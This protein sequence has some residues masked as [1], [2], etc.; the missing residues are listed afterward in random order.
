LEILF[1][2]SSP[3]QHHERFSKLFSSLGRV[4]SVFLNLNQ[5]APGVDFGLVVFAD[6]DITVE[7]AL[8]FSAPKIGISWAW[9]LQQTLRQGHQV[10]LKLIKALKSVE[11]LVVDNVTLKSK[12][13]TLGIPGDKIF[14]APYGINIANFP[15]PKFREYK[16]GK[17][18]LYTNRKWEEVYRPHIILEMA[19]KLMESKFN[20]KL[21]MANDGT[22]R[23]SLIKKYSR[24]FQLEICTWIGK[25]EE[26]RNIQELQ[27]ADLYLSASK[28]DGTSLSMLEAMV[29][30]TPV[31]VTDN[32]SNRE[33]VI[34]NLTG[35]LFSGNSGADLARRIKAINRESNCLSNNLNNARE[36]ILIEANWDLTQAAL[37]TKV[38]EIIFNKVYI[39]QNS[40]VEI[41]SGNMV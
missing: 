40:T 39:H 33:W 34:D 16:D 35:Y 13:E 27:N 37:I 29:V 11:L 31:L 41:I 28:S 19:E 5:R 36:K 1:L 38:K 8:Q 21:V 20:F 2:D 17:I 24:L 15:S 32:P 10:F 12:A 3:S 14:C 9:D 18:C 6:L 22:L 4:H 23:K 7:Y 25:I 30:G 26:S